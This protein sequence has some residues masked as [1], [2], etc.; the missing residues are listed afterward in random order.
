MHTAPTIGRLQSRGHATR[1]PIL[2]REPS[3]HLSVGP[4]SALHHRVSLLAAAM[5]LHP[6]RR[7]LVGVLLER[8]CT[9]DPI[10]RQTLTQ[11]KTARPGAS[12][13]MRVIA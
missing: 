8:C 4:L 5:R 9:H 2:H 6:G 10:T 3:S 7:L 13:A 1:H 11:R 12:T